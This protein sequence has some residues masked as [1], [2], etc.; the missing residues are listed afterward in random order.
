[1]FALEGN[2]LLIVY[3]FVAGGALV[4]FVIT[5]L[6][7]KPSYTRTQLYEVMTGIVLSLLG[8]LISGSTLDASRTSALGSYSILLGILITMSAGLWIFFA[9]KTIIQEGYNART[10]AFWIFLSS[11]AVSAVGISFA[12][13]HIEELWNNVSP[14]LAGIFMC[15]GEVSAYYAFSAVRENFSVVRGSTV[16]ILANS[17]VVPVILLSLFLLHEYT[18]DAFIGIIVLALGLFLM[19]FAESH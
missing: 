9:S 2:L 19:N 16:A 15:L 12:P 5:F 17:E 11:F 3:P 14:F 7:K 10:A 13:K 18:V 4:F 8:L 6:G 1:L